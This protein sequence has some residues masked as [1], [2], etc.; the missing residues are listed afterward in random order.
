MEKL[1]CE[2]IYNQYHNAIF[3]YALGLL[4]D[5]HLAED[6]MQETFLRLL[7]SSLPIPEEKTQSWLY[8]IARNLCYDILRKKKKEIAYQNDLE[9]QYDSFSFY[10][11]IASLPQ[12]EQEIIILKIIGKLTHKEIAEIL[13]TTEH[14]IK[15]RYERAIHS[16]EKCERRF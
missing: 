7:K 4:H 15:K 1:K 6:I 5:V 8:K 10:E 9:N 16:L 2:Y 11:M 13:H 14:S 12:K 3:R